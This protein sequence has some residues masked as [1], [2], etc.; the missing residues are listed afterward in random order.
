MAKPGRAI[1]SVVGT[2]V[3]AFAVSKVAGASCQFL[4]IGNETFRENCRPGNP[5]AEW[6]APP[7]AS[8]RGFTTEISIDKGEAITFLVDTPGQSGVH[9]DL[10]V[11]RLGFLAWWHGADAYGVLPNTII[12]ASFPFTYPPFAIP[13]FG[14][15]AALSWSHAVIAMMVAIR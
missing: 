9:Y 15:F 13:V 1:R 14:P 10:D 3:F 2:I 7:N 8:I 11:Y 12:G 4:D 5:Q 6:Y